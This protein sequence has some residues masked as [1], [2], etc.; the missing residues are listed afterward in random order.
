[1]SPAVCTC[2]GSGARHVSLG[3]AGVFTVLALSGG[4]SQPTQMTQQLRSSLTLQ[5]AFRMRLDPILL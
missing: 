5:M 2:P 4:S 3:T 1:M